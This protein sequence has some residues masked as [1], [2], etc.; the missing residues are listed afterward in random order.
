MAEPPSRPREAAPSGQTLPRRG[1]LLAKPF[2]LVRE[3]LRAYLLLNAIVYGLLIVGMVTGMT[4][5]DLTASLVAAAQES[6]S[7]D[8]IRSLVGKVPLFALVI[9]A[10]NII[11]VGLLSIL[12]PSLIVPFA[13]IA[14][15]GF[16]VFYSGLILAPTTADAAATLVPHSVTLILEFQAYVILALGAY[17]L[18]RSWLRPSSIGAANRRQG[19]VGGLRQIG[20]LSLL[21]LLLL[22]IGAVYEAVS[23]TYLIA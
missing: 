1:V 10:N 16:Q 3:N 2:R 20:W 18:G 14:V 4:F 6:A 17:V 12:L 23:V 19:Y 8:V 21:A 11:R 13:G 9:L 22:I 5:P 15:L 7:A